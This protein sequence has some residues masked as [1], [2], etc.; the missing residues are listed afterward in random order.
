MTPEQE[1]IAR[2]EQRLACAESFLVTHPAIQRG[3]RIERRG[4]HGDAARWAV[5]FYGLV[6]NREGE[7]EYESMP[8]G[9]DEAFRQRTRFPLDE[10][11]ARAEAALEAAAN[12]SAYVGPLV[13]NK[14][15]WKR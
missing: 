1:T 12:E 9:R 15:E 13:R 4:S 3:V 5:G 2:L 7:W 8:S 6:L 11:F 14:P 10:A